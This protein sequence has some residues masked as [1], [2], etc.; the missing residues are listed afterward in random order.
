MIWYKQG[1]SFLFH[2][3]VPICSVLAVQPITKAV[4][5]IQFC[6]LHSTQGPQV[7]LL[8]EIEVERN[9]Q[10]SQVIP[11]F[12]SDPQ[13]PGEGMWMTNI[14]LTVFLLC[15]VGL[16]QISIAHCAEAPGAGRKGNKRVVAL[17]CFLGTHAQGMQQPHARS[18]KQSAS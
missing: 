13:K 8:T 9:G 15:T 2:C 11:S 4:T 16:S 17:L 6:L 14:L 1:I 5:Q 10:Q 12:Y 3:S 7:P 18:W